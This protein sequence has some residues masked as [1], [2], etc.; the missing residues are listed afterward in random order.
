MFIVLRFWCFL[1][2]PSL[3][4]QNRFL[5]LKGFKKEE[6]GREGERVREENLFGNNNLKFVCP[7]LLRVFWKLVEDA[8]EGVPG[9]F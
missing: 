7:S 4:V 6:K 9:G 5:Q 1:F 3:K 8:R 2:V